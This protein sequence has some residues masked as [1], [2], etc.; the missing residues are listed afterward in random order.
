MRSTSL[1]PLVQ[2]TLL[3]AC[4]ALVAVVVVAQPKDPKPAW[5]NFSRDGLMAYV[6]TMRTSGRIP[7]VAVAVVQREAGLLFVTGLGEHDD[8]SEVTAE[9]P[10]VLD[11]AAHPL[12]SLAASS[13]AKEGRLD[14]TPKAIAQADVATLTQWITTTTGKPLPD[15]LR[16]W[17]GEPLA[18][19]ATGDPVHGR[20]YLFGYLRP[21]GAPPSDAATAS[22]AGLARVL[23]VHL[24]AG[25]TLSDE[26]TQEDEPPKKGRR[27]KPK[28]ALDK[29]KE[30]E[31][32]K[33]RSLPTLL[34]QE[35]FKAL[36]GNSGGSGWQADGDGALWVKGPTGSSSAAMVMVPQTGLGVAVLANVN[37]LGAYTPATVCAGV[38]ELLETRTTQA[39]P[40]VEFY[41]RLALGVI[42]LMMVLGM[43][44]RLAHWHRAGFPVTFD[45]GLQPLGLVF[46][47]VPLVVMV[48]A[49]VLA[50]PA[51]LVSE[52]PD[53]AL[54]VLLGCPLATFGGLMRH[55][56][57]VHQKEAMDALDTQGI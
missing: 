34:G 6:E 30:Q 31:E 33:L 26:A 47:V 24:R 51:A 28:A 54:V 3:A 57:F 2:A 44:R 8:G 21:V 4:L 27:R 55:W 18:M 52:Q 23:L 20:Q 15:A 9:T 37:S 42:G 45:L 38:L 56:T 29:E 12:L 11:D 53:V 17:V 49:L 50:S 35:A 22:A 46:I 10:F 16:T 19:P 48:G 13:L 1:F 7:A 41:L 5:K 40:F 39:L 32:R 36:H 14:Q 43:L 25:E